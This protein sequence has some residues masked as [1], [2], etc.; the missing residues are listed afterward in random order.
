MGTNIVECLEKLGVM[1][2]YDIEARFDAFRDDLKGFKPLEKKT[3]HEFLRIEDWFNNAKVEVQELKALDAYAT[4]Q[5]T[6]LSGI[7]NA[8]HLLDTDPAKLVNFDK[9]LNDNEDT[10]DLESYLRNLQ[11]YIAGKY[12]KFKIAQG[13]EQHANYTQD[14]APAKGQSSTF[15]GVPCEFCGEH[16]K[17]ELKN[18]RRKKEALQALKVKQLHDRAGRDKNPRYQPYSKGNSNGQGKGR[19]N[20]GDQRTG[21]NRS[22]ATAQTTTTVTATTTTGTASAEAA[23][24]TGATAATPTI[25]AAEMQATAAA[26]ATPA[27]TTATTEARTRATRATIMIPIT[28]ANARALPRATLCFWTQQATCPT[29]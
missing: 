8:L 19:G 10:E 13:V 17:H 27:I 14:K 11:A 4:Q 24:P 18:C 3:H 20:S 12:N 28:R 16:S 6:L 23:A 29:P 5:P 1:T 15:T 7:H 21:H 25:V 2:A 26:T 22:L 9:F